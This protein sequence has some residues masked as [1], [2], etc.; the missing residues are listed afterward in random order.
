MPNGTRLTRDQQ[1]ARHAYD[2][3]GVMWSA[4]NRTPKGDDEARLRARKKCDNYE[5]AVKALGANILRSG[6]S[7][8]LADLMRRGDRAKD[9]REHI[10][11]AASEL[12]GLTGAGEADLFRRVN[13]LETAQYMLTTRELLQV[14]MWLKRACEALFEFDDKGP[15][16]LGAAAGPRGAGNAR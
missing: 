12:P 16:A 6:L 10:A 5:I 11:I 4:Y 14:V 2:Q 7:A 9:L 1:R 3:V 15:D 8:A 13:N